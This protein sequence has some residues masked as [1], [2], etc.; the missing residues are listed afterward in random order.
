MCTRAGVEARCPAADSSLSGEGHYFCVGEPLSPGDTA[1][2]HRPNEQAPGKPRTR[3]LFWDLRYISI[4]AVYA[5]NWQ[6][7]CLRVSV[8]DSTLQILWGCFLLFLV[9]LNGIWLQPQQGL[10]T[11]PLKAFLIRKLHLKFALVLC[12]AFHCTGDIMLRWGSIN[13][14]TISFFPRIFP[15][16]SRA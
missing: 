9:I 6:H 12:L 3:W 16:C 8:G 7:S 11:Y 5:Q 4:P 2:A 14:M 13:T 1:T 10:T 15:L